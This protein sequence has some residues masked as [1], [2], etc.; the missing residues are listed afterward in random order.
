MRKAHYNP[1]KRKF[2][3]LTWIYP[4]AVR[5]AEAQGVTIDDIVRESG[6]ARS[7]IIGFLQG[8][9]PGNKYLIDT[10]LEM[11]GFTYEEFFALEVSTE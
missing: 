3:K 10:L 11:S 1:A 9:S 2:R 7:T 6:A 4:N 8:R 5:W